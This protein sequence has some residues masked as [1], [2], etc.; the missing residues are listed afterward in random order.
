MV[1]Y[2]SYA[3]ETY[4]SESDVDIAVLLNGNLN[5]STEDRLADL[6]VDLN[7]KYDKTFSV[8]ILI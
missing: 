5:E 6:V 3:R 2:G 1:L 8:L 7:L 4:T